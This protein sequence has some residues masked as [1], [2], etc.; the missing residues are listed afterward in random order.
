LLEYVP[1]LRGSIWH[2]NNWQMQATWL[3]DPK[4]NR[5]KA[6]EAN[7]KAG[8]FAK[9]SPQ[10]EQ[11]G[12]Y[13]AGRKRVI[14]Q[15]Q[16]D[17]FTFDPRTTEWTKVLSGQEDTAPNGHDARSPMYFDPKSGHGLLIDFRTSTLWAYD[18]DKNAWSK[19]RPEGEPMPEG[20][21]RLAYC[22]P[23]HG[24]FVVIHDTTVWAYRY[25]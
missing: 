20:N 12:Y 3:Y 9:E 5:W 25:R 18:P 16:L 6:L 4:T 17:T 10:P 13:D 23:A 1:E 7:A 8:T 19:L 15:R 11:V 21:K 24:V 22:D 14:V 2:A